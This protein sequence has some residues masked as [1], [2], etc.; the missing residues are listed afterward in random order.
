MCKRTL[1]DKPIIVDGEKIKMVHEPNGTHYLLIEK[2]SPDYAG[3]F[4]V[5][6]SNENG[7]ITSEAELSVTCK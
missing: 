7:K 1:N 3:K 5:I 4:A 2:A 6:V